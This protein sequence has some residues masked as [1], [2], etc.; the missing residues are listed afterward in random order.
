MKR[1]TTL[2]TV[3]KQEVLAFD[4]VEIQYC[5]PVNFDKILEV[6]NPLP[7]FVMTFDRLPINK[8]TRIEQ[9]EY[10]DQFYAFSRELEEIVGCLIKEK[11]VSIEQ[12]TNRCI[13]LLSEQVDKID[14]FKKHPWYMRVWKAFKKEIY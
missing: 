14:T 7:E 5:N 8:V 11:I 13:K 4:Y 1:K 10:K 2:Y 12:N 6:T 3:E 9:G